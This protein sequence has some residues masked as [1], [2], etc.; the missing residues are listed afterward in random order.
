MTD[1]LENQTLPIYE[2]CL[3]EKNHYYS[4]LNDAKRIEHDLLLKFFNLRV[5]RQD[6]PTAK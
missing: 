2:I 5:W 3:D 1:H 4:Y 6:P